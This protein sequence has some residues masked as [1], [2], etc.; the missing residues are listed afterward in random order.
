MKKAVLTLVMLAVCTLVFGMDRKTGNP[1][2]VYLQ[3]GSV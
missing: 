1:R 2:S 3:K